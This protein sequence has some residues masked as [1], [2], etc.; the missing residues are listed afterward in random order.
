MMQRIP[1]R[2][3]LKAAPLALAACRRNE[4]AYFGNTEPPPTQHTVSVLDNEPASLDPALSAGLVDSLILSLFEGLT[5]LQPSTAM[6]MAALA[7]HYEL[8]TDGLRYTF[9]LR[10]HR[11]PRGTRLADTS[12]LPEDYSRGRAAPRD[13]AAA[14]WSDGSRINSHDFVYSW[15]RAL[16]PGMAAEYAFLL[17][18]LK[19]AQA[20]NAG[21]LSPN[22][23]GV[24]AVDDL[25]LEAELDA[26][27]PYFLELVSNRI[28]CAVPRHVIESLGVR[29]TDP[30]NMVSNGAFRLR[31]RRPY[32]NIGLERNPH[33]YDA[34]QVTLERL[35]FFI[36]RDLSTLVNEYRTG[37]VQQVFPWI[38][39]IIPMLRRK[40]DFRPHPVYA[41][42]F[43][44]I[45]TTTPPFDD[46]RVRY[47]LNMA[48]DK[49]PIADSGGAGNIPAS[50]VVP[51][52]RHHEPLKSLP[53]TIDGAVCDVLSYNP[54]AAREL[55]ARSGKRLP[56]RIEYLCPEDPDL[57]RWILKDQWRRNLGVELVIR[58]VEF[59][60]WL[61]ESHIGGFPHLAASGSVGCFIDPVWF[62]DLFTKPDGYGTGWSDGCY[63][64][65]LMH[66]RASADPALR[67]AGI[68]ACERRLLEAMPVVPIGHWVNSELRKPFLRGLGENLLDRQ[69]FK[70]AWIDT[71]WRAS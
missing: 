45:N 43:V 59:Q 69:Q 26:P 60:T 25:T 56:E 46:V 51:P 18:P 57:Q 2:S 5:S 54:A 29:W 7:T 38:P 16:D 66:A 22:Q 64:Q 32:E 71:N 30:G 50:G 42:D 55:L 33:Y 12:D 49:R 27:T 10:G 11:R 63:Q 41:S 52:S 1:R 4:E 39:A 31:E 13:D 62:L 14:L 21:K 6:P 47:A 34:G 15:R 40:K 20:V 19:N 9:Y 58:T 35:T 3:L 36:A 70:Y 68:A 28:A 53:V 17:Y 23:L 67:S 44:S 37:V 48:T 65:A 24:R 8:S 61:R